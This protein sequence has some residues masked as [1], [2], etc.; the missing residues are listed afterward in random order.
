MGY[1]S[2]T[3]YIGAALAAAGAA[4]SSYATS[5][6]L[7]AQ[8]KIAAQGILKQGALQK[9]G[10][11]DVSSTIGQVAKSNAKTQASANDQLAQYRAA[12]QQGSG[13]SQSASPG[14][15]GA[16][17]AYK[18]EQ[19]VAG[20]SAQNYT[21]AIA[22]SAATTQGTQLE[23]VDENQSMADTAGKLG[24]LS[25]ESA[26]QNY[27]T[28]LQVQSTRANPWLTGLGSLMSAAGGASGALGAGISAAGS[29]AQLR[30]KKYSGSGPAD[31]SANYNDGQGGSGG[32]ITS[33]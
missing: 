22:K 15:P 29:A 1:G 24:I 7:K 14:I 5:Q 19:A 32:S 21:D 30:S 13:I 20:A 4:T 33:G 2:E 6:Q 9:Q 26:N 23:R 3:L 16:S 17:K 12:L 27:L 8:D 31:Y 28:K 18:G 10:E 25:G 11:A